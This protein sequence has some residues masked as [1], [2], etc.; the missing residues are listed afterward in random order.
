MKRFGNLYGQIIDREN[1]RQAHYNARKGKAH[2]TEVQQVNANE[3]YFIDILHRTLRDKTFTTSEYTIFKTYEPK[4]RE[5]YKLPYFPDRI[6]QHALMQICQPIWD[7]T[8]IYDSYAAVPKK[9]I[10][11][12]VKR[13]KEFL[14]DKENTKYCLKFDISKFYPN[15]NHD[16]LLSLV[17][18]KIKC[19][20]TLWLI[21]DMIR[22]VPENRGIPI[23]NY[24]S[25]YL[26]NVYLNDF[27]HWIKETLKCKYYI[28]YCD[29]AI[30][31][32]KDK[33]HLHKVWKEI[34]KYLSRYLKLK[35][36]SKTQIFPVQS[37]GID[38]LGYKT[39]S[40][41]FS[42]LRKSSKKK[43]CRKIKQLTNNPERFGPQHIVSSVMSYLGWMCHCNA[44]NLLTKHVLKNDELKTL[45]QT[46]STI[47]GINNPLMK[48][49]NN[50]NVKYVEGR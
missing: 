36:N 29:D 12:G 15:I 31:L 11:A 50:W 35:L 28:R 18:K 24:L 39:Y 23:G 3:D 42:L 5:I 45:V 46:S 19:E 9:G 27:D 47:L 33:E 6:A 10:H 49:Q 21:E 48:F 8:F 17:K 41:V 4:E 44:H 7:R 32:N 37:R 25:Q 13:L 30:I 20:D 22:S 40:P 38:F 2:Y 26:S 43:F 34:E 1:L 14:R 16:I